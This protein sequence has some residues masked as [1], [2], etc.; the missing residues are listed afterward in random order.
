MY[1]LRQKELSRKFHLNYEKF[2]KLINEAYS[3]ILLGDHVERLNILLIVFRH[4]GR[5]LTLVLDKRY[6]QDPHNVH[7]IQLTLNMIK[8][9]EDRIN[10]GKKHGKKYYHDDQLEKFEKITN[11]LKSRMKNSVYVI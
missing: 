3:V 2:F 11:F 7:V 4:I 10:E 9:V 6:T 1:E 5:N 8:F